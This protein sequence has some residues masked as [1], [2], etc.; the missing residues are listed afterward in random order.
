MAQT[1]M[2]QEKPHLI[3]MDQLCSHSRQTSTPSY[4]KAAVTG[5]FY[6]ECCMPGAATGR[7]PRNVTSLCPVPSGEKTP[8]DSGNVGVFPYLWSVQQNWTLLKQKIREYWKQPTWLN[9]T[10]ISQQQQKR[11]EVENHCMYYWGHT[12]QYFS[13]VL[14]ALCSELWYREDTWLLAHMPWEWLA[15]PDWSA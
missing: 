2:S 15:E 10:K 14:G 3:I 11:G 9:Q 6:P 8:E 12:P 13:L 5:G 4:Q 7:Q 1:D